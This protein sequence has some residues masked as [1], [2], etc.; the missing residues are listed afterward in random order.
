MGT[1]EAI[2]G[3]SLITLDRGMPVYRRFWEF[4][5]FFDGKGRDAIEYLH[6]QGEKAK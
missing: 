4:G 1:Y 3:S 6:A 5:T 2:R